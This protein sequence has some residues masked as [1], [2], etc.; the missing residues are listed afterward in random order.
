MGGF[1]TAPLVTPNGTAFADIGG[2][3]GSSGNS[4]YSSALVNNGIISGDQSVGG[5]SLI[6]GNQTISG[7][8]SV[9][10]VTTL[11]SVIAQ[12]IQTNTLTV[13]GGTGTPVQILGRDGSGSVNTVGVGSGLALSGGILSVATA[14]LSVNTDGVSE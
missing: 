13:N 5:N 1:A 3:V 4:G 6:A 2:Y 14:V 11:S 9:S 12:D 7:T 10:G 8:L